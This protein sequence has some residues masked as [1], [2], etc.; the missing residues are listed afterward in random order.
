MLCGGQGRSAGLNTREDEKILSI[1][2]TIVDNSS[3]RKA[4][5]VETMLVEPQTSP[6]RR[7]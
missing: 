4:S 3:G 7:P 1:G 5:I 2:P 6:P